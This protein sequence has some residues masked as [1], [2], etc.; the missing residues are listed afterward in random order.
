MWKMRKGILVKSL[1]LGQRMLA[2]PAFHI[3]DYFLPLSSACGE[4][5]RGA[6]CQWAH[7][8]AAVSPWLFIQRSP[9]EACGQTG[10]G[11]LLTHG[12][13]AS[14][15][16]EP[17]S[18]LRPKLTPQTLQSV[19]LSRVQEPQCRRTQSAS[20]WSQP[21]GR[22]DGAVL[23]HAELKL[24]CPYFC[25]WKTHA[26]KVMGIMLSV[27]WWLQNPLSEPWFHLRGGEPRH[28]SVERAAFQHRA[29]SGCEPGPVSPS[30]ISLKDI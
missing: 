8:G 2:V 19:V 4:L 5:L 12:S 30:C 13:R 23:R 22:R 29:D 14:G 3:G 20:V 17:C 7:V 26:V 24:S 27:H 11:F 6:V 25:S 28:A 10:S 16:P 9:P 15:G 18:A 1:F 21:G